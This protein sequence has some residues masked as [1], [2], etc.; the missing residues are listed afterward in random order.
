[1]WF[2]RPHKPPLTW[3]VDTPTRPDVDWSRFDNHMRLTVVGESFY[4]ANLA[5]CS[6]A[7]ARGE[8]RY[9]CTACLVPEPTNPHDRFAVR[10]EIDG[11]HVGYLPRGSARRFHRRLAAML[12]D[13]QPTMCV[14]FVGRRAEGE[15]PNLGV[16][17]RIPYDGALLSER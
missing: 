16:S 5:K 6:A 8:H 2:N 11:W 9:E 12:A 1:M 7:P 14:A 15:N 13:G 17:L 10:V 3:N 4:Q